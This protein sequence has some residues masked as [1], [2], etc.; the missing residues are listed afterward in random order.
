MTLSL[1]LC[2]DD[3]CSDIDIFQGLQVPI[4]ICSSTTLAD[5]GY[6]TVS[7]LVNAL[8]ENVGDTAVTLVLQH[9]GL[10]VRNNII[11]T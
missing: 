2:I 10:P 4:P 9:L 5:I 11:G 3:T 6:D 1:E 8:D 7:D